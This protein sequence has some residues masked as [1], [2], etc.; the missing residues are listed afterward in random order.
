[1]QATSLTFVAAGML[2][3]KC[4]TWQIDLA[5]AR[6]RFAQLNLLIGRK[7]GATSVSSMNGYLTMTAFSPACQRCVPVRRQSRCS[8]LM[9]ASEKAG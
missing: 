9:G 4:P 5:E 6:T 8:D 3:T 2:N 7:V 1:M